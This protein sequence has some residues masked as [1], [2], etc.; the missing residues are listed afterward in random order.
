MIQAIISV[1]RQTGMDEWNTYYH[2]KTFKK[3]STLEEIE[4][5]AKTYGK[6]IT[7]FDVKLSTKD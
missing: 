7:I 3:T 6:G 2:S 4:D 1:T 5:W